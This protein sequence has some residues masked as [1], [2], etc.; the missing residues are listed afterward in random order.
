MV[1][2]NDPEG[3]A[4]EKKSGLN[5]PFSEATALTGY[6]SCSRSGRLLFRTPIGEGMMT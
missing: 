3:V 6:V 2:G 5:W 1:Q 4:F